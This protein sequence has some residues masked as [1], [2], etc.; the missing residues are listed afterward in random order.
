MILVA[1]FAFANIAQANSIALHDPGNR[2]LNG[3]PFTASVTETLPDGLMGISIPGGISF[4]TFCLERNESFYQWDHNYSYTINSYATQGGIGGQT[5]PSRDPLD[6]RSAYLY[7]RFR[8]DPSFANTVLKV[9]ALQA[10]FWHIEDE[11]YL[12]LHP[13]AGSVEQ[14]AWVYVN[15]AGA[16]GW[17]NISDVVVLNLYDTAHGQLQS[18][19]GLTVPEPGSILLLGL[20]LLGIALIRRKQ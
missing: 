3:G 12:P 14:Q 18:Q 16:A 17:T 20:G 6:P 10:A 1:A 19:L 5:I 4:T 15:A 2:Y 8:T 13:A 9:D 11:L 7:Y